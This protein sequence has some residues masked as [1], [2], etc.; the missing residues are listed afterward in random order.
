MAEILLNKII[1][2][3]IKVEFFIKW[4]LD[5]NSQEQY[6]SD[7]KNY[8]CSRTDFLTYFLNFVH[9]EIPCLTKNGE[10]PQK[11][12]TTRRIE[13]QD[14]K[15]PT[16]RRSSL[17]LK[18]DK[19]D[20]N[21][22]ASY[23]LA[24]HKS[25]D[26]SNK[27]FEN[28]QT[29]SP[30][31]CRSNSTP[32][33]M[34]VQ[35]G[36]TLHSVHISPISPLYRN[37]TNFWTPKSERQSFTNRSVE[38]ATSLCLGDFIVNRKSLVK[39]KGYKN[40][41]SCEFSDE[42]SKRIKPTNLN[43]V[44]LN[45]NFRQNDNSFNNFQNTQEVS[46][47]S[48]NDSRNFLAEERLKILT[49]RDSV[50]NL[51]ST[52]KKISSL[53]NFKEEIEPDAD[54]VTNKE[55]LNCLVEIYVNILKNGLILNITSEIYFL[56]SLLLAKHFDESR[57]STNSSDVMPAGIDFLNDEDRCELQSVLSR[58][59]H[60]TSADLFE[61]VHNTVYFAARCLETQLDVLK[62]Y[63]KSTLNL[64]CRN[65]RLQA[66][67]KS[68]AEKLG[69]ISQK[70]S[71]CVLE[72]PD[73]N[74]Q[75]NVCFNLDTDNRDN[76]P[77]DSAFHTFRK[78]RDLFYEILRIWEN[79]HLV[80]NWDFSGSLGGRIKSLFSL[81]NEPMT[82]VHFTRLFK[83][84]LLGTCGRFEKEEGLSD[85]PFLSSIPN[86]D[87]D[88]LNRLNCRLVTK[89]SS[90]GINSVPLF[91]GHQEFYKDFIVI[92]ANYLFNKHLCD[93]LIAEIVD[94]NDTKFSCTDLEEI[95][96]SVDST[97]RKSYM[98]CLKSLRILAKFLGFVESLPYKTDCSS[99]SEKV[100]NFQISLRKE[101]TPTF[102]VK[103]LL[104]NSIK[105]NC[106]TLTVPWLTKYLSMLDYVTLRLPYYISV[107]KILFDLHKNCYKVL[108]TK[109]YNAPL[110]KF[111]LGWLFELPHFPDSEYF[112]FCT[113]E[114]EAGIS[115]PGTP[116]TNSKT[117]KER[118]LDHLDI[119][120]QNVLYICCP[121]LEEI[122]KLLSS[123]AL[124]GSVTV[125][126][127]TPVTAVQSS[128]KIANK[129]LEQQLEEAFFNGQ[130]L[131]LRK[132]VEFVSE[133]V[134]SACVKH[135]CS[136][137]VPS[138]KKTAVE[139][140][141]NFLTSWTQQH[142][143]NSPTREKS[144]KAALKSKV[145]QMTH[146]SL[147]TLKE[148]CDAEVSTITSERIPTCIANLL[149]VDVL[150]QTR[151]VCVSIATRMCAERVQQWIN[152]HVTSA[153]FM[154]DFNS[155]MQKVLS[156]ESRR[157]AK[158]K[159]VFQLPSGGTIGNHNENAT[160][161]FHLLEKVKIFSTY[162][163]ENL[164]EVSNEAVA[165]ILDEAYVTLTERSD[166]NECITLSTC[167][168]LVDV[169]LLLITHKPDVM[170]REELLKKFV[171][172]WKCYNA[173][174]GELFKNLLCPRNVMLLAQSC[175]NVKVW[176]TFASFAAFL[177]KEDILKPEEFELQCTEFF[178]KEW[179]QRTLGNVTAFLQKFLDCYRQSGGNT[180]KFTL[181]LEFLSDFCTDLC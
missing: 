121:F 179:D 109:N 136:T 122:K 92:A 158:E 148:N 50:N 63:N 98:A 49:R 172:V 127:I 135:I 22:S 69:K 75:T 60:I 151:N 36:S 38:K 160:S 56:I 116:K 45:G 125:K 29:T 5:T 81:Q 65:K 85:I 41:S 93:A 102:D 95:D 3:E 24:L 99:F 67:S 27:F 120:D 20:I 54:L 180:D 13:L 133:R 76:F 181:L 18:E 16:R 87:A 52:S 164:E 157:S 166:V 142:N 40:L 12:N 2:K 104:E 51:T 6:F 1:N 114:L 66:F 140:V 28:N 149:S 124:K 168:L 62:Y 106:I 89:Q 155:E 152:S 44:K 48:L 156:P 146:S 42:C 139:N 100:L 34:K 33:L 17:L 101:V 79:Q 47:D 90:S 78:Q 23:P 37:Q 59:R 113:E 91:T 14:D 7:S 132:T 43:Q 170:V 105:Q 32:K 117:V 150:P 57:E 39:K 141:R 88:K 143:L 9:E 176:E 128:T 4:L 115:S 84:Q 19:Y 77:N 8:K 70:K 174:A 161:A 11:P 21:K 144:L 30:Q 131:S 64:L 80:A 72:F 134:A 108:G 137:I 130:P 126:H 97:T 177:L 154:K 138:F 73:S 153:V 159:P 46:V 103:I 74:V 147:Q 162:I 165:D 171:R 71:E 107:Y 58:V 55:E 96:G 169:S 111:C 145:N 82:F 167:A 94:L 178:R 31:V 123:N 15:T 86:V 83:A 173:K 26:G 53:I 175:N 118:K 112:N 68:F 35:S 163:L 61:T 110:I 25:S 119:I 129:R 10:S